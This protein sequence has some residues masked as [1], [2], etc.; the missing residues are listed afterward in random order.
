MERSQ[1]VNMRQALFDEGFLGEQFVRLEELQDDSEPKFVE[2]MITLFFS[3]SARL[4]QNIEQAL[5]KTP[6]DF[7]ELDNL[8][9][10]VNGQCLSTGTKRVQN[11]CT[12]CREHCKAE[13]EE[14][15]RRAFQRL[16][17][18]RAT[19]KHKLDAYFQLATQIGP[20]ETGSPSSSK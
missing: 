8:L 15:C 9:S 19:L 6:M 13:D 17:E 4:I 18:E 10:Q 3:D 5:E 11:E 2:E 16:K 7:S 14:G 20:V 12:Q 1:L